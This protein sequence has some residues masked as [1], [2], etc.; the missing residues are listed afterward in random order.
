MNA[1]TTRG[2]AAPCGANRGSEVDI[3]LDPCTVA[4][5]SVR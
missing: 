2:T 5:R 3:R 1:M 4:A